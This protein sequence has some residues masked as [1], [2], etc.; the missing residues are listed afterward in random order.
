MLQNKTLIRGDAVHVDK[1]NE[2]GAFIDYINY[3]IR[4]LDDTMNDSNRESGKLIMLMDLHMHE[5]RFSPDSF[6]SLEEIV[7]RARE[8]GLDGI[9][10]TDHD[11]M[12]L[13]DYAT[14]YAKKQNYPIIVGVEYL[15]LDGDITAFG[16][17]TF[18]SERIPAQE[19]IDMVHSQ[20]GVCISAH[21]FRNN[22]RG[23]EHKLG[24][25]KGLDGIEAFN[26]STSPEA[27]GEALEYCRML[28]IQPVGVSDCHV[29]EKIGQFATWLPD[30]IETVEDFVA[31]FKQSLCYPVRYENGK[32]V[33][34]IR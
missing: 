21:P 4:G 10:I 12:G 8:M 22:N 30:G 20:G 32:Y 2:R 7:R 14:E 5:R 1:N 26:A 24:I 19:F 3:D 16:I 9:C 18:P 23:L 11:S 34:C 33:P 15:S 13:E 29:Y 17:N 31:A 28:G 27:N 25:V 6:I